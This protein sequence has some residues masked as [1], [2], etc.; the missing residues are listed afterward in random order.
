MIHAA[1][2]GA[3]ARGM[4]A[5][6]SYAIKRPQEMK[7]VAVAEPDKKKRELFAEQHQIPKEN[8]FSSWED[9]LD[10]PKMCE[11]VLICTSDELHFAPTMQ[12]LKT[13]YHVLLE[14]PM[15]TNLEETL[16]MAEE[17]EK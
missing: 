16:L 8:Q 4:N 15:S 14:K 11:A 9:L 1:L 10:Q 3:G 7:F 5:L 2:I 12:A 13:G 17:S 6:G